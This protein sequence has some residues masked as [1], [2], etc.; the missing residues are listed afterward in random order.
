MA[1]LILFSILLGSASAVSEL[2]LGSL[3]DSPSNRASKSLVLSELLN[4]NSELDN[5]RQEADSVSDTA[6]ASNIEEEDQF[7]YHDALLKAATEPEAAVS[8][9]PSALMLRDEMAAVYFKAAGA[10]NCPSG[11]MVSTAAECKQA[12]A[13]VGHKFNKVVSDKYQRPA[14]CFW[15]QNGESYFNEQLG[16]SA[17]WGG[18]G[19]ICKKG[20]SGDKHRFCP[21]WASFGYCT[22]YA[23]LANYVIPTCCKSCAHKCVKDEHCLVPG[24]V[25]VK[26]DGMGAGGECM[27]TGF[28]PEPVHEGWDGSEAVF[29]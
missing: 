13:A 15:D 27:G 24:N 25:C 19:A 21:Y 4:I 2:G 5:R 22:R 6:A 10:Q 1:P 17:S 16:A 3:S 11:Q 18:V 26:K 20:C 8:E 14:G 7:A 9:V 23:N 12:G 28:M 29:R